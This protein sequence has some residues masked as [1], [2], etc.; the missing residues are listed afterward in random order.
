MST[1][2]NQ[3]HPRPP[4]PQLDAN[5]ALSLLLSSFG[6]ACWSLTPERD[7]LLFLSAST[8]ELYGEPLAVLAH[9][10]N[11]WLE[12]VHPDDKPRLFTWLE[13]LPYTGSAHGR[14]RIVLADGEIVTVQQR[15]QLHV[16]SQG[17]P[18]RIDFLVSR[19]LLNETEAIPD[20]QS[21]FR[22][23]PEPLL[24][25]EPEY[26]SIVSANPAACALSGYRLGELKK[27]RAQ[28][29]GAGFA[30]PCAQR[31]PLPDA[32]WPLLRRDEE[33]LL[34]HWRLLPISLAGARWL[35]LRLSP[36]DA[37]DPFQALAQRSGELLLCCNEHGQITAANPAARQALQLLPPQFGHLSE[38][39]PLWA[40]R[41]L[42]HEGLPS[43]RQQGRWQKELPMLGEK[44]KERLCAV[45]VLAQDNGFILA[46]R[47]IA[48]QQQLLQQYRRDNER[49]RN[50]EYLTQQVLAN[51]GQEMLAPLNELAAQLGDN[52]NALATLK[53]LQHLADNL[54]RFGLPQ[55]GDL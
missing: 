3:N 34:Q 29:L 48:N 13:R 24:L 51:L 42:W 12:A 46:A 28:D 4:Q 45:E 25:C 7:R 18:Q 5:P 39:M 20:W 17:Q 14:Y 41:L 47:D 2:M 54:Q 11:F 26:G 21:L 40:S 50:Q 33:P 53:R 19:C 27:M 38:K 36:P 35:L 16:D 31:E 37:H 32:N 43:A 49:L 23:L 1:V 6:V 10:P 22:Q 44:N 8:A 30:L 15:C 9:Y 52:R 55:L